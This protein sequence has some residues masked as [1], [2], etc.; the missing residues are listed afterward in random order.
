MN[1]INFQDMSLQTLKN[2]AQQCDISTSS[3]SKEDLIRELKNIF[4]IVESRRNKYTERGS[5]GYSGKE[6]S[7]FEVA[8]K[9]GNI[10]AM[11]KFRTGKSSSRLEHEALLLGRAGD[12][13]IAPRLID[14]SRSNGWIVM[15]RLDENLFDILKKNNGKISQTMQKQMIDLFKKLDR[16]GIFHADPNPLN[17]MFKDGKMYMIDFGFAKDF[18]D[19]SV[20]DLKT[21]T[22][23]MDFMPLGF[24]LKIKPYC[25]V[26]SFTTLIKHIPREKLDQTGIL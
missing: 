18:E 9:K 15:E 5:L 7:V 20:R 13:G 6:G 4:K 26:G 19:K 23:N 24:L 16:V 14:Y 25:D 11:K 3:K 8:D 17:F 10:Y 12:A 2:L 1:S 21:A 22:P